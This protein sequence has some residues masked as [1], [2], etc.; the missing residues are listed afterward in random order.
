MP[1]R[2]KVQQ[3]FGHLDELGFG[4]QYDY[5]NVPL[6]PKSRMHRGYAFVNFTTPQECAR[7]KETIVGTQL[8]NSNSLK[9]I[10]VEEAGL[11][12]VAANVAARPESYGR[13]E[14]H[15]RPAKATTWIRKDGEMEPYKRP[16]SLM[17]G[18]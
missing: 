2:A 1:N 7:C 15:L 12:G 17:G 5:V 13:H 16:T 11:Q 8:R 6:D 14:R 9:R 10:E 18:L 4:G 3:I